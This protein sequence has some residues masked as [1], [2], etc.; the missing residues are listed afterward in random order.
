MI[1]ITNDFKF[2][3]IGSSHTLYSNTHIEFNYGD[4]VLITGSSGSGKSTLLHLIKGVL[5][6]KSIRVATQD[7]SLL[8]QNPDAQFITKDAFHELAFTLENLAMPTTSILDAIYT[9]VTTF[10]INHLLNRPASLLSR[11][12]K[13]IINLLALLIVKPKILLLDEPTSFL[14]V[15]YL[16]IF[17]TIINTI[18]N[19]TVIIIADHNVHLIHNIVN[20]YF[21][22]SDHGEILQGQYT[23]NP[24]VTQR[25]T[26]HML[27]TLLEIKY[28]TT[29]TSSIKN[30]SI[31]SGEII[32][33]M[34]DNGAGKSTLL[35]NIA[36]PLTNTDNIILYKGHDI[37]NIKW[38]Q[39][40][41]QIALLMQNSEHHFLYDRVSLEIED[42][43][44]LT[45]LNL[46]TVK[47]MNPFCISEGQ[48]RRLALGI[49]CN[50]ERTIY[51][52]DDP[53]FGQ[54]SNNKQ[55]IA[56]III[57]MNHQGKTFLIASHDKQF[58][59]IICDRI[60]TLV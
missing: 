60:I 58:L 51:L 47:N 16:N 38:Q 42:H 52:L 32:G 35:Q 8:L 11:G 26:K 36:T 45:K 57:D 15:Q 56:D 50:L 7:I 17:I 3:H 48:K 20:R 2:N 24:I 25:V 31:D 34:G 49:I 13:Q 1:A 40:Y 23:N 54:D 22:L 4:V 9:H 21:Y 19:D 6:N 14:D 46:L 41:S 30:I 37:K 59:Q 10:S 55:I 39:Y 5:H 53:T 12:E 18:K 29:K 28:C 44:L 33:I 43:D 27:D